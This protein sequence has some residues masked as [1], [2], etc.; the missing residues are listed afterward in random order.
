MIE[1]STV[2]NIT[3][4]FYIITLI[5]NAWG[6]WAY[7]YMLKYIELYIYDIDTKL[8]P[9]LVVLSVLTYYINYFNDTITECFK[10]I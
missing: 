3:N 1:I 6:F 7:I 4:I 9:I 2:H 5:P 8:T 10:E